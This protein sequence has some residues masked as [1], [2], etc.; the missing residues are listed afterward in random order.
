MVKLLVLLV[1]EPESLVSV[2]PK[3][4]KPSIIYIP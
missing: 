2:K 4:Y 3:D 1:V